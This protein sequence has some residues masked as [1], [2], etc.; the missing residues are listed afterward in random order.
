MSACATIL[1]QKRRIEWPRKQFLQTK[2]FGLTL[3]IY[4][5]QLG[6]AAKLPQ[7]LPARPTRRRKDVRIG[8]HRDSSEP[9]R[10]FRDRLEYRY[11]LGAEGQPVGRVFDIA[12]GE[13]AAMLV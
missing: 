1:V 2:C 10:A 13:N 12:P 5:R 6:I 11:T 4:Q 9:A 7:N 3:Q 8:R